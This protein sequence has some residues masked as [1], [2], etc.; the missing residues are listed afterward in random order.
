MD[1]MVPVHPSKEHLA[2]CLEELRAFAREDAPALP[3]GS[4]RR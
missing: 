4:A 1:D 3:G 2:R